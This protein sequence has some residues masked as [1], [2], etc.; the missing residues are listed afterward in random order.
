LNNSN[1]YI[2]L[3]SGTSVDAID[4]A[5]VHI[6]GNTV[7]LLAKYS[8]TWPQE[9]RETILSLT[10]SGNNTVAYDVI[11][12]LDYQVAQEFALATLELLRHS[13][14]EAQRITAIGCAG[15][16]LYHKPN[17]NPSYTRQLGDPNVIAQQ[18]GLL[19]VADFRRRDMAAGGQGAP[20]TPAFHQLLF[21]QTE[22]LHAV[23]NLGG[24]ANI[25]IL[26]PEV[27]GFDTGPGNCLLDAWIQKH[28]SAAYDEYGVWASSGSLCDSL[29]D[30][31]LTDSYFA[32]PAP[33]TTG[34][35]Y[36]NLHWLS[37]YLKQF[38]LPPNIIQTTLAQLTI[39]SVSRAIQPYAVEQLWVCGGG[40]HNKFLMDGL[41]KRLKCK[42]NS[43]AEQGIEPDWLEAMCFA[44]LA[45]QRLQKL[46]SNLPSVTG[47]AFAV[48][49]GGIYE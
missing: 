9:L 28:L 5:L 39:E 20:L 13:H 3:M 1:F 47:A 2:G 40:V 35:D 8:H 43:T 22:Q 19:T 37:P 6:D 7:N 33:K 14:I 16:T 10:Q 17:A 25:T 26:G 30:S 27:I 44:W 15:Q 4:A 23:L 24:I 32:K 46:P 36:F 34:R 11:A 21:Q 41:A 42:I 12:Q 45:H 29:L 48:S 31:L 38:R 49:L 18:T